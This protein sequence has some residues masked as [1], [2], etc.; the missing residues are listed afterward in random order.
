[1][2]VLLTMKFMVVWMFQWMGWRVN[3]ICNYF[4]HIVHWWIESSILKLKAEVTWWDCKEILLAA[5]SNLFRYTHFLLY[6][7]AKFIKPSHFKSDENREYESNSSGE[8]EL[9]KNIKFKSNVER[10]DPHQVKVSQSK[11]NSIIFLSLVFLLFF[12]Q[13]SN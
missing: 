9:D 11:E 6:F 7:T 10:Y 12:N 3:F 5:L 2:N 8:F 4:P 13:F 1:M